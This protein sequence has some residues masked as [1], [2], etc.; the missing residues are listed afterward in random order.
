MNSLNLLQNIQGIINNIYPFYSSS[1]LLIVVFIL[2]FFINFGK[3]AFKIFFLIIS[4][5][6][7]TA[8]FFINIFSFLKNGTF[9]NYL[10]NYDL[11]EVVM[12]S[13][14][15][16][17][18]LN[19][20]GLI[21]FF[22]FYKKN[23]NKILILFLFSITIFIFFIASSNFLMLFSSLALTIISIFLLVTSLND[24][25]PYKITEEYILKNYILRFFL[26]TVFALSLIFLGFSFIYGATDL[27]SFA[28]ILEAEKISNS[29]AKLGIFT[30]FSSLFIFSFIFPLQSPYI[31][32]LKRC[33]SSSAAVIWFL[34]Y[35]TV[36]FL[37]LKMRNVFF[38]LITNSTTNAVNGGA[39]AGNTANTSA[40]LNSNI[41]SGS[42]NN[43]Y[44][45]ISINNIYITSFL[46]FVAM[47]CLIFGNLGAVKTFSTRRI[48]SFIFLVVLGF[49]I[50]SLGF[51]S[52]GI[53][54]ESVLV[55]IIFSN[56]ACLILFYFPYSLILFE[57]EKAN[58]NDRINSFGNF[59]KDSKDYLIYNFYNSFNG[60]YILINLVLAA[61]S[62]P[63]IVLFNAILSKD[64]FLKIIRLVFL[65][66][67]TV[68]E[69]KENMQNALNK[70]FSLN[71]TFIY[72]G[73][74]ILSVGFI[75]L[76]YN[77]IRV[78]IL[79]FKNKKL[80][81]LKSSDKFSDKF[82]DKPS[83]KLGDK[84]SDKNNEISAM[85]PLQHDYKNQ[86]KVQDNIQ[87]NFKFKKQKSKK[88]KDIF[89]KFYY[90][91]ITIFNLVII[92]LL[93]F[94]IL[95]I[96]NINILPFEI[97]QIIGKF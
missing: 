56:L 3:K 60:K 43:I 25:L 35:S 48:L 12:I 49:S 78:A 64:G 58:G 91:Y 55:F 40:S 26:V 51:Y 41:L 5:I 73:V 6:G 54:N 38:Y 30:L 80:E 87:D 17:I 69:S 1:S 94:N 74:I 96:F 31:K 70:Y 72:L 32:L 61:V 42:I 34:Y 82:S 83:D 88:D 76:M 50:L 62:F 33:E 16:F 79:M 67:Y 10:F 20:L 21:S 28:Q 59:S 37:F 68:G 52:I 71:N 44:N 95:Q 77:L 2:L 14:V 19:L 22:N 9:S 15:L 7:I 8:A 23:F 81:N 89:P 39:S 86:E 65:S 63:L 90:A 11:V 92:Y 75:F 47:V 93:I 53:F 29:M 4:F 46:F 27:K 45:N 24:E 13:L 85:Q 66:V 36:I 97:G 57:I 18:G 84:T